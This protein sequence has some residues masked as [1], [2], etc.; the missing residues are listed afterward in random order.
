ML[1]EVFLTLREQHLLFP[2]FFSSRWPAFPLASRLLDPHLHTLRTRIKRLV[3]KTIGFSRSIQM[4][5][6]VI[7]LSSNRFEFGLA[8]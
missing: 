4:H 3:R 8:V 7:G 2:S 6:L 5:D 1:L